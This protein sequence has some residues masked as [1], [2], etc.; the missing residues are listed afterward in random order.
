VTRLPQLAQEL[1]AAAGRLGSS[2]RLVAPAARVAIAIAAVVAIVVTAGVVAVVER[3][4]DPS[5]QATGSPFPPDATLEDMLG[6]FREPAT[7]AD[8]G[9]TQEEFNRIGNHQP[10]EDPTKSRRVEWPGVSLFVWPMRD[11]V[12]YDVPG[13]GGCPPLGIIRREGVAVGINSSS[14]RSSL[15]GVVVDGIDEVVVSFSTGADL[16]VPVRENFFF[17]ELDR[18]AAL[19]VEKVSWRYGDEERSV[20]VDRFLEPAVAPSVVPDDGKFGP[21]PDVEPFAGSA[22]PPLSFQLEGSRVEAVGYHS[23][24]SMICVLLVDHGSGLRTGH[25]CLNERLL[26]DALEERPAHL[27]AGG[28]SHRT[29]FARGE[30]VDIAATGDTTVVLSEPWTPEP[31]EGEPIRFFIVFGTER[32]SPPGPFAE[33]PLEVRLSDGQTVRVP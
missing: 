26:V 29:G 13:G 8:T 7:P 28:S 27:F 4:G 14:E 22:S 17:L 16:T 21:V 32:P 5:P 24:R 6:V 10:G 20:D 33:T 11:G 19:D 23:S 2:R 3:G 30:V 31:W 1:V 12:C 15:H 25:S 9:L 18:A